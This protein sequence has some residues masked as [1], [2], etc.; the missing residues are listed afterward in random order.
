MCKYDSKVAKYWHEFQT[1][2]QR[3]NEKK[4]KLVPNLP[5]SINDL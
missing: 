2:R 5:E 1:K 4:N 3:I